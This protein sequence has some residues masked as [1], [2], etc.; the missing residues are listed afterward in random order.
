MTRQRQWVDT[1]R[2]HAPRRFYF[3]IFLRQAQTIAFCWDPWIDLLNNLQGVFLFV[4]Y[5][6][7]TAKT[8]VRHDPDAFVDRLLVLSSPERT[9]CIFH[10]ENPRRYRLRAQPVGR[11]LESERIRHGVCL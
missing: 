10:E 11:F 7:L 1:R 6:I 2:V 9:A 3:L 5:W 4:C 8:L